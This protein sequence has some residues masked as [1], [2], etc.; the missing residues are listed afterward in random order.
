MSTPQ[1]EN[2]A[3]D[4]KRYRAEAR[5]WRLVAGLL[6]VVAGLLGMG[7]AGTITYHVYAMQAIRDVMEEE[8]QWLVQEYQ[9]MLDEQKRAKR[10]MEDEADREPR[11]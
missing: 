8:R 1:V 10:I 9:R 7:L 3:A 5:R 2:L 4:V 6:A 11:R